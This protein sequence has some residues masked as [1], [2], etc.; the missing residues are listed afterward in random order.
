MLIERP[1]E[2]DDDPTLQMA[3]TVLLVATTFPCASSIYAVQVELPDVSALCVAKFKLGRTEVREPVVLSTIQ[4]EPYI[5][6]SLGDAVNVT[7]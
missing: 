6:I 2:G 4:T 5:G 7:G 1:I 3:E